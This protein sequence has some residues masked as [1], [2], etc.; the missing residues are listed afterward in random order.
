MATI[1]SI[2]VWANDDTG[3]VDGSVQQALPLPADLQIELDNNADIPADTHSIRRVHTFSATGATGTTLT[4]TAPYDCV[5]TEVA[6][7]KTGATNADAGDKIELLDATPTAIADGLLDIV[8]EVAIVFLRDDSVATLSKG[9]VL[10][11]KRTRTAA[12]D[13]SCA[14]WFDIIPQ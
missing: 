4:W 10:T 2:P 13:V 12:S 11:L 6:G 5:V 1:Y 8:D 3:G 14:I 7:Y 9:D